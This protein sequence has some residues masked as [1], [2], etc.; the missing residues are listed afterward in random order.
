MCQILTRANPWGQG[1][2]R[3]VDRQDP[4]G[5]PQQALGHANKLGYA[6]LNQQTQAAAQYSEGRKIKGDQKQKKGY[7]AKLR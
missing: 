1:D 3:S 6:P 2:A 4:C 7:E 5:C